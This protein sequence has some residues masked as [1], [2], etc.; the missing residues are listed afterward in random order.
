[1]N[2]KFQ[3]EGKTYEADVAK[4]KMSLPQFFITL[5]NESLIK[6][7]GAQHI[8]SQDAPGQFAYAFPN[9][10][11]AGQNLMYTIAKGLSKGLKENLQK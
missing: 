5:K 3:F 9:S 1:M 11:A 2:I 4:P 7:F 6:R 10:T 8:I